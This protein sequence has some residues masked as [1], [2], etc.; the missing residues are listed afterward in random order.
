MIH[1]NTSLSTPIVLLIF[2]RPDLTA[3]VFEAIAQVKPKK[4]L[5][6]ADG[7]RFP[8]E[9]EKCQ[10]ARAVIEK[11]NWDCEVL[12]NF[13]EKNLG[14]GRRVASG[15]DW[16]FSK[17]EEAIILEDDCIPTP[18]FFNFCQVLLDYYRYDKRVM[19]IS[20]NNFQANQSRTDYS[21][22]LSKYSHIWGW[23]TWRRAWNH[24]DLSMKTWPKFKES[25]MLKFVCEDPYEQKYWTKTFEQVFDGTINTVWSYQW[26]YACWCQN[27]LSVL[28]NFNLVSNIGFGLDATHT[29]GNSCF[30][31]IPTVDIWK[32]DHP[33]FIVRH[34]EADV[35]TFDHVFYGK[36]MRRNAKLDRRLRR[37][38]SPLK[39]KIKSYLS[40]YDRKKQSNA[41]HVTKLLKKYFLSKKAT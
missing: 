20:G 29:R 3:I 40:F 31:N 41:S 12:T 6:V 11:V 18:S 30:S 33:Q 16:V 39:N 2:N 22:Y 17:V 27:G 24:F 7:P 8:E 37:K 26:Q 32:I 19:H 10:R 21:Y 1:N 15:L 36:D 9:A 38:L 14:C 4:L 13:S 23:A 35:Y 25:G 34:Q 5:V 28:P